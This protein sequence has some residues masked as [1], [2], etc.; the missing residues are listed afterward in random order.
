MND[1]KLKLNRFR[2]NLKYLRNFNGFSQNYMAEA[3]QISTR[4][5]QRIESGDSTP[6]LELLYLLENIFQT[7]ISTLLHFILKNDYFLEVPE[8]QF[9][10]GEKAQSFHRLCQYM[11]KT[12]LS[13]K[14]IQKTYREIIHDPTFFKHKLNLCITNPL[15]MEFLPNYSFSQLT[16][17]K[18]GNIQKAPPLWKQNKN[19]ISHINKVYGLQKIFFQTEY[20]LEHYTGKITLKLNNYAQTFPCGN[21]LIIGYTI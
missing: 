16:T 19:I 9:L 6:T 1:C 7:N 10:E 20:T 5:Y 21:C 14:N 3:L 8:E 18:P 11:A 4:G 13:E 15:E 2:I 17:S 12:Y